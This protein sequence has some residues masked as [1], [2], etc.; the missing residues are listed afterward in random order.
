MR[1]GRGGTRLPVRQEPRRA[2]PPRRRDAGASPTLWNSSA[3]RACATASRRSRPSSSQDINPESRRRPTSSR[4]RA[5]PGISASRCS[6]SAISRTGATALTS[7]APIGFATGDPRAFLGQ[8]YE[9]KPTPWLIHVSID[10]GRARAAGATPSR[11]AG[12]KVDILMPRRG[13]K[14][15]SSPMPARTPPR[16]WRAASPRRL[17]SA[18]GGRSAPCS[19]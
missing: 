18:A 4:W 1:T 8:F 15:T 10:H 17:Q 19:A 5:R 2:D 14:Q 6:S 3:P 11:A 9:D 7:P 13:E 12:R 16:P